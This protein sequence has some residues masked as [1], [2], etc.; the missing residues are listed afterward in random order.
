M[1]AI[2]LS[3]GTARGD[4]TP[5]PAMINW[6]DRKPY[7][8]VLDQLDVRVLWLSDGG[9]DV[10]IVAWDLIDTMDEA[11]RNVRRAIHESTGIPDKHVIIGASHTH[12][13]PR[14]P[15]TEATVPP[16]RAER[17]RE[18]LDDPVW[19]AWGAK[20][21][22]T[23]AGLA[24]K[25]REA[26]K[27]VSLGIGRADAGEWLF[28]RRPIDAEGKVV[29]T[30]NPADP[31]VLPDGLRFSPLDPTLTVLVFEGADGKPVASLF[32]VPCH[33]VSIYPH[34]QGVSADWP[35]PACEH[36]SNALGGETLFLQGC[37]GDIVPGRRGEAARRDM[38]KFFADRAVSAAGVRHPIPPAPLQT[39]S[40]VAGLPL[41]PKAR[42][43]AG[44]DFHPVE[45]HV[46]A[47]GPLALVTLPGEP[48]NGLAREIT[49]RSPFPHTLVVGYS[50][51]YSVGYV[52][53]P[54]E[55]AKGGYEAGAGRGTE[56]AG[57]IMIETAVRLLQETSQGDS[58][59]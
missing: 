39:I 24:E 18:I 58:E 51:G 21:P 44:C 49:A 56:E 25:A 36:I 23:C 19:Q 33:S 43:D 28:N 6:V 54:G 13:G 20:L 10:A 4:I 2:T 47:I 30:F 42:A 22:A 40:S 29:T 57:L 59:A 34:H 45:I 12:S 14:S 9:T 37:A 26:A 7:D 15:F 50:N 48:L 1:D 27:P 16:K 35:G 8:G 38:A 52:G 41:L 17:M 46:V 31:K 55:K 11:V 32:S 53:L 3:A 5:D